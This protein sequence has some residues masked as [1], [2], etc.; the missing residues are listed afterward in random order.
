LCAVRSSIKRRLASVAIV[1]EK[2]STF[3]SFA[4]GREGTGA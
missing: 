2:Q 4:G 3:E 1:P